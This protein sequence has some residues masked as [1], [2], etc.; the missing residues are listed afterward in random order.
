M[1]LLL[2]LILKNAFYGHKSVIDSYFNIWEIKVELL[3]PCHSHEEAG[4][5]TKEA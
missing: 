4:F 1:L 2:C 5:P 3:Q